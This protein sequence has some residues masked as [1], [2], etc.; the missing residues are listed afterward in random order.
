MSKYITIDYTVKSAM[1]GMGETNFSKYAKYL[2][3]A[4]ECCRHELSVVLPDYV[5][6]ILMPISDN[7]TIQFPEDCVKVTKIGKQFGDYLGILT[8]DDNLAFPQKTTSCGAIINNV[9]TPSFALGLETPF[10]YGESLGNYWFGGGFY[11]FF[12]YGLAPNCFGTYR[13]DYEKDQIQLGSNVKATEL[14][15]EYKSN[16]LMDLNTGQEIIPF[17]AMLPLRAYIM[18][19]EE[20]SRR[21]SPANEKERKHML[22]KQAKKDMKVKVFTP[23]EAEMLRAFRVG[24]KQSPKY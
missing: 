10:P 8:V 20:E 9:E 2:Q 14:Y 21:G 11:T 18:W 3:F 22:Y 6:T 16:G 1:N 23:S 4:Y 15:V 13:I 24:Y 17:N 12:G 19:Q 7:L 5:K